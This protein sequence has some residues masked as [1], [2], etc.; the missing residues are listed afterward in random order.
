VSILDGRPRTVK[1]Y[2]DANG[3][4]LER[5]QTDLNGATGYPTEQ[6][7]YFNGA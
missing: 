7:F 4:V 2:N 1:F 3:L 6:H 5:M